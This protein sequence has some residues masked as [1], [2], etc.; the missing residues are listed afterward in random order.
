MYAGQVS[1][2]R[3]LLQEGLRQAEALQDDYQIASSLIFLAGVS[4]LEQDY[5][6]TIALASSSAARF[7][8]VGDLVSATIVQFYLALALQH[9]GDSLS[10]IRLIREGLLASTGLHNRWQLGLAV[11]ATVLL[12]GKRADREAL[13]RLVGA[14]DALVHS[15]GALPGTLTHLSRQPAVNSRAQ[16]EQEGFGA[17]YRAGRALSM[18]DIVDLALAL[19]EAFSQSL[20]DTST[21]PGQ[22]V[23]KNPLSPRE[24]EVLRLV[25]EGLTS[26]QIGQEIFLSPKTVNHHL[27]SVFN[28]LGVDSRAQA[29]A[30]AAREGLL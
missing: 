16:L 28:K 9:E 7:T 15:T 8:A 1:E 3:R 24:L 17:S 2:S 10:A 25:A 29:V 21:G 5:A 4:L 13:A 18:D 26:K 23:P 30:V 12:V 20:D 14:G 11:E 19:L 22:D 6:E 27:T